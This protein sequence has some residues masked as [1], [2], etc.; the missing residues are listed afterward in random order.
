LIK[1]PLYLQDIY[2]LFWS[3]EKKNIWIFGEG[4]LTSYSCLSK[5]SLS[6]Q[7]LYEIS[8]SGVATSSDGSLV[9]TGDCLGNLKVFN[10]HDSKPIAETF[11]FGFVRSLSWR[12]SEKKSNSSWGYGRKCLSIYNRN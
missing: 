11:A 5:K 8:C 6:T 4:K 10:L 12:N 2:V 3:H 7:S 1:Y 9:T